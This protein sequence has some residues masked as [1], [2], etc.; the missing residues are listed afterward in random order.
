MDLAACFEIE[1]ASGGRHYCQTAHAPLQT[2][3]ANQTFARFPHR[4]LKSKTNSLQGS[5]SL[6]AKVPPPC[7]DLA[8]PERVH[9]TSFQPHD[10]F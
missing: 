3:T 2:V 4:L 5:R 7:F 8:L 9:I 6:P 10:K 1:F